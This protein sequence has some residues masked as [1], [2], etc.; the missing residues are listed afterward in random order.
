M[1]DFSGRVAV[2]TGAS[3]GIGK[4]I[5]AR[6]A[7]EG[8]KVVLAGINEQFLREVKGELERTG[9]EVLTVRTDVSRFSDV[10]ELARK[11][12][13]AFGSVDLLVNNAGVVAGG[14][15]ME[16]AL[17]DWEWV[18]GVN[19]WGVIYGLHVFVPIMLAQ[20]SECHVVNT[21]SVSGLLPAH[22]FVPY[23]V[24]KY[25]VVALTENL[26]H[27]LP[28]GSPLGVSALCPGVVA[29]ALGSAERNR[30]PGLRESPVDGRTP[31]TPGG[32]P[33]GA[34]DGFAAGMS[35]EEVASRTFD[36]IRE[37]RLYIM[38]HPEHNAEI[39]A[40]MERILAAGGG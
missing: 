10:R 33:L 1:R 2:I 15:I 31:R 8:M 25:A 23:Q 34:P 26:F 27:S 36:G 14:S 38:T 9:A 7:R 32:Q 29:T 3:H 13:D 12:M 30:P 6:C 16:T 37:K 17:A 40:R 5:A 20:G 22:P 19:L 39:R 21:A 24:T 18:M 4:A 28:A 11:T 35:A